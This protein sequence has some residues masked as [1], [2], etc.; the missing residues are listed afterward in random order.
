VTN[1]LDQLTGALHGYK[2]DFFGTPR[3]EWDP[4]TYEERP[5]DV[6]HTLQA[7]EDSNRRLEE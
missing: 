3:R 2:G 7:F 1:S 5:Y 6:Q 4:E